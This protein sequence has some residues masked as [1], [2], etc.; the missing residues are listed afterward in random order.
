MQ[1]L[2]MSKISKGQ[3]TIYIKITHYS[4]SLE[5]YLSIC[6]GTFSSVMNYIV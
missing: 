4:S 6:I 2:Y 3:F 1:T 5:C